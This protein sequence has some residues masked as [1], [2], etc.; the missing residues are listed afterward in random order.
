MCG[1]AVLRL[2]D[3]IQGPVVGDGSSGWYFIG[4]QGRFF[5]LVFLTVGRCVPFVGPRL[6]SD[7]LLIPI[8]YLYGRAVEEVQFF[9][10]LFPAFL[11][12]FFSVFFQYLFPVPFSSTFFQYFFP[13][14]FSS[15]FFQYRSG[16]PVIISTF[17]G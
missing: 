13:V 1:D 7:V 5:R 12:T 10:K 4:I 14:P 17:P 6:S 3:G 2:I 16:I 9:L 11:S 8:I 15:T